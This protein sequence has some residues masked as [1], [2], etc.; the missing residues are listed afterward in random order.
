MTRHDIG[1]DITT[2]YDEVPY[3]SLP[4][5]QTHPDRLAVLSRLLGH[6]SAPLDK[7]RVLELGCAAGGNLIPLALKL[8]DA[9][10]V[11]VDLSS[12]QIDE[13]L[14]LVKSLELSNVDLRAM[15]ITD[16]DPAF[17]QFDYIIAHGVYSWVPPSVQEAL[18]RV[19]KHNLTERGV[20]YVS[21]NVYPGWHMRGMIRDMMRYH[22]G[23]FQDAPTRIAQARALLAFLA[24]VVPAEHGAYGM[25]LGIEAETLAK[26]P[27]HY[28]LHEHLEESNEPL[29]FHQFMDRATRHG[30]SYL[31]ESDFASMTGTSL[32]PDVAKKLG[33][34]AFDVV[35][36]EQYLDFAVNRTFRQT[37]LVHEPFRP[38]RALKPQ[39]M[40]ELYIGT[41]VRPTAPEAN[42]EE[43]VVEEFR[44]TGKSTPIIRSGEA[45]V[46]AALHVL[47]QSHPLPLHFEHVLTEARARLHRVKTGNDASKEADSQRLAAMIA[48]G[49]TIG[50]AELFGLP[51]SFGLEPG[52]RPRACRLARRQAESGPL[53]TNRLHQVVPLNDVQRA[54]LPWLD[55]H[56]ERT[57]LC[58]MFDERLQSGNLVAP[59]LNLPQSP[60][61]RR[62]EIDDYL[63][64]LIKT[65]AR[66]A[67]MEP[68]S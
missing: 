49:Y 51:P 6:H 14:T 16:I 67:L 36:F 47:A 37:L 29:Y 33:Q 22:A 12:R 40:K 18:L 66:M 31:G 27:D 64:R 4:F 26:L 34:I 25:L 46:K 13:G 53:V 30:L 19:C 54:V 1:S 32:A 2:S 62:R 43:G 41:R 48:Q 56:R 23:R 10:F 58:T 21:Y 35:S 50:S 3:R 68:T 9:T 55:G 39:D 38:N 17:G 60:S 59:G 45:L 11:G 52:P 65:L 57:E 61:A 42:L 20:A 28:I 15:S 63:S 24:K 7:C 5:P 8:P 44:G